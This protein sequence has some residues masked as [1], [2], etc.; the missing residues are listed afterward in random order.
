MIRQRFGPLEFEVTKVE[1]GWTYH[2]ILRIKNT[3]A[4]HVAFFKKTEA[5]G[6]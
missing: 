5:S 2:W 6:E 3:V 4:F 1:H